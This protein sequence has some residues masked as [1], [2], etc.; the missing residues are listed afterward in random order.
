MNPRLRGGSAKDLSCP[1]PSV[2]IGYFDS[3]QCEEIL[4]LF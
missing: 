4:R 2:P 1:W 3:F